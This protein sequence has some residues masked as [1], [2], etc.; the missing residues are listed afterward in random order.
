MIFVDQVGD[1]VIKSNLYRLRKS[2]IRKAI[3][4]K[5]LTP[6]AIFTKAAM[7]SG[8]C[9][10]EGLQSYKPS[11]TLPSTLKEYPPIL[12]VGCGTVKIP[13]S[14]GVDFDPKS[15]ADVIHNL[16]EYPWPFP[17]QSFSHLIMWHVLEHLR[18]PRRAMDELQRICKPGATIELATP[19]Y[20]S[21]DSWGDITH[22]GHF[23][24]KTLDPFYNKSDSPFELIERKL[25]FS[26]GLPS[27]IG[28]AIDALFGH[29][30]YEKYCC[31]VF[32]AGNMEFKLRRR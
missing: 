2:A 31:F 17:D 32:R 19:H 6:I 18:N 24:L 5:N 14:F 21:P 22:Y 25:T 10:G 8:E 12:N 27:L 30:F 4:R 15:T 13:N 28:R 16:D 20:S 9:S 26:R 7:G 23:S 29:T 1:R 11:I 3:F